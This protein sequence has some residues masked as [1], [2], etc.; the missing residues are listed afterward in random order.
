MARSAPQP[1]HSFRTGTAFALVGLT[2]FLLVFG[3]TVRVH[4]AGLA[5]P[6]W[7]LCF[8][9]VVPALDFHVYLEFGHRVVAG[10]VSLW[11][12]GQAWLLRR[13]GLF[14]RSR[15]LRV[16][17]PLAA[18]VLAAQVVLG[19]LTVLELLAEWTVASHLLTGNTF[20]LCLLLIALSIR[21]AQAPVHRAPITAVQRGVATSL[22]VLV[23]LQLALG[24][25]V[26]GS[27]AGL[28]CGTWPS[29][30]GAGWFPTFA[31][32]VGLQVT[33]RV[34]AYTVATA[35]L[36]NL[37]IAWRSPTLRRPAA[38]VVALVAAQITLGVANVLMH[39][40]L[41]ITLAH[42]AG[43]AGIMLAM[44]WLVHEA[45]RAPIAASEPSASHGVP[46]EAK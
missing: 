46:V 27:N 3:S 35:A 2:A 32:L 43:A 33:H 19:G 12:L 45:W 41:E 7:P 26:A 20:A 15:A 17:Y 23:P 30:N 8:G 39:L 10:V 25:L 31:G 37:A 16:L 14:A 21:E 24:G 13:A 36:A 6:D 44:G 9:Q 29:C 1:P 42:S 38:L 5:C 40:K 4:G 28:A 22:A 11:F 34:V 18:V